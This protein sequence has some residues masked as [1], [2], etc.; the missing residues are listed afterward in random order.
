[1][2]D[3]R[4]PLLMSVCRTELELRGKGTDTDPV[5]RITQYWSMGGELLAEVDP[6]LRYQAPYASLVRAAER[7]ITSWAECNLFIA[8][9]IDRVVA[10]KQFCEALDA[11]RRELPDAAISEKEKDNA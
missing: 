2:R 1:M 6:C 10:R 8:V 9:T 7:V 11:L 4:A 3:L 5:R